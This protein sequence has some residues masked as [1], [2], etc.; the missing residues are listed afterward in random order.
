M[1]IQTVYAYIP[2]TGIKFQNPSGNN[3]T[4]ILILMK[5]GQSTLNP[6]LPA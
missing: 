3:L 6:Y 5:S 4:H 2:D 1:R